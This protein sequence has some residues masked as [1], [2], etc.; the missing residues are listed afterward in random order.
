MIQRE[1]DGDIGGDLPEC[2]RKHT[3]CQFTSGRGCQH[4]RQQNGK[5]KAFIGETPAIT[6][7]LEWRGFNLR[8]HSHSQ[9]TLNRNS[10]YLISG[11]S[12]YQ[13]YF[14]ITNQIIPAV[15]SKVRPR[16]QVNIEPSVVIAMIL[17]ARLALAPIARAMT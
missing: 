14:W 13:F 8:C 5:N 10:S 3:H 16:L 15:F 11:E 1:S 12:D 17:A 2:I 7:F 6:Q 9:I 4:G